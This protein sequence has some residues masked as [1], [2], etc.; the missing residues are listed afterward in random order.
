VT[1]KLGAQSV[2][3]DVPGRCADRPDDVRIDAIG[4]RDLDGADAVDG[5]RGQ[6]EDDGVARDMPVGLIDES[7]NRLDH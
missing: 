4:N 7:Q 3:D 6:A 1:L 2:V 5:D